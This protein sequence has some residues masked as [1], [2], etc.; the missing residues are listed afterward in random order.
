M[1]VLL[2]YATESELELYIIMRLCGKVMLHMWCLY[3]ARK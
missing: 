1:S 3:M 2:M